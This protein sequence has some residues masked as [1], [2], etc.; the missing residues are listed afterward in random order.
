[1][2]RPVLFIAHTFPPASGPGV[3][4][5]YYFAK[6]LVAHG[7]Q[8]WVLTIPKSDIEAIGYPQDKAL[9]E[10]L[11]AEVEVVRVPTREP[12]K[13]VGWLQKIRIFRLVWFLAYPLFWE[14]SAFWPFS[15]FTT[16]KRIIREQNIK[17]IYTTSGPFSSILLGFL[18]KK[19]LPV[20]WVL[21]IRD[22]FTDGYM[23]HWPSKLHWY[24]SRMLEKWL[25][26]TADHVIVNTPEVKALYLKR[27]LAP[28]AKLSVITN[29]Y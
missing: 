27:N 18:L 7:Y 10:S 26:R 25:Y 28:E 14:K 11:P 3:F 2:I 17:L 21:D 19:S 8:P 13:L 9:E 16:A 29:G 4:R 22:P 20:K 5:S 1:M 6:E 12:R 24:F 15:S 23:W